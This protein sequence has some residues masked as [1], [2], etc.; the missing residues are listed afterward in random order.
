MIHTH[1]TG[2]KKGT[3]K[4]K[5]NGSFTMC[6]QEIKRKWMDREGRRKGKDGDSRRQKAGKE[7]QKRGWNKREKGWLEE[8]EGKRERRE[9][10][11]GEDKEEKRNWEKARRDRENVK[12]E[13]REGKKGKREEREGKKENRE[14]RENEKRGRCLRGVD[15]VGWSQPCF[16]LPPT[17]S[18]D[19]DRSPCGLRH[20]GDRWGR[21]TP[22]THWPHLTTHLAMPTDSDTAHAHTV[23]SCSSPCFDLTPRWPSTTQKQ[24]ETPMPGFRTGFDNRDFRSTMARRFGHDGLYSEKKSLIAHFITLTHLFTQFSLFWCWW[25]MCTLHLLTCQVRWAWRSIQ[26]FVFMWHL[27]STN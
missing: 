5:G 24:R 15:K 26:V 6:R 9:T 13:E 21:H 2:K 3:G 1:T 8:R 14:K 19:T 4:G 22:S 12:N 18:S 7:K 20:H 17:G 27:S 10:D 16:T 11:K 23:T 25:S